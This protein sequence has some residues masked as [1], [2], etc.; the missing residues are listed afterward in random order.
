MK[1]SSLSITFSQST[2]ANVCSLSS[3]HFHSQLKTPAKLKA[4][5]SAG[6]LWSNLKI[7]FTYPQ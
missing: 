6:C 2:A 4:V 1:A 5:V 7:H 3:V